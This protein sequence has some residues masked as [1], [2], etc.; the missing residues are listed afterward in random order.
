[1]RGSRYMLAAAVAA[2][3][4]LGGLGGP[5]HALTASGWRLGTSAHARVLYLPGFLLTSTFDAHT[6]FQG[7]ST[8]ALVR[9]LAPGGG[10]EVAGGL[11]VT[12]F[13]FASGNW[14]RRGLPD[15]ST[16]YLE[17]DLTALTV[18]AEVAWQRAVLPRLTLRAA[19]GFGLGYIFGGVRSSDVLPNCRAPVARCGHWRD[20]TTRHPDLPTRVLPV[21]MAAVSARVRL[22]DQ[23]SLT[24][25]LGVRDVLFAGCGVDV[26]F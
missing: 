15:L 25:E 20:V 19:V 9:A 17:W 2:V 22:V 18:E 10:F 12:R 1:M 3:L 8:G 7:Y 13:G 5:A 16:T 23:L 24:A 4:V 6:G 11:E 14:R 26:W 21:L